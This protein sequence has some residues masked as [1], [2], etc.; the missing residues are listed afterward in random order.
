MNH[1]EYAEVPP[2]GIPVNIGIAVVIGIAVGVV[3]EGIEYG[4]ST[5][6]LIGIMLGFVLQEALLVQLLSREANIKFQYRILNG[7]VNQRNRMTLLFGPVLILLAVGATLAL[8]NNVA[9]EKIILVRILC[10]SLIIMFGVDP[11]FGLVD[12]GVLAIFG[13]SV[14]YI[15][16]LQAGFDGYDNLVNSISPIIGD[17]FAFS[18]ATSVVAYLLLSA[19]W[20]YYRLFCFNQSEDFLKAFADT[21]L[22]LLLVTLPYV[23]TFV[24]MLEKI[25][26]GI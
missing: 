22:P 10:V 25:F 14:V 15:I 17:A 2:I 19:R 6:V 5:G 11:L 1:H 13:A 24:K 26:L 8:V 18:V 4:I 21:G 3:G 9:G 7:E 23:P 20:T 16:I 12:R